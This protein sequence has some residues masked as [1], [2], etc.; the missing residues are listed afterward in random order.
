[1]IKDVMVRLDGT[2]A[3]DVRLAAAK[4]M[5]D[6]FDGQIIG[7]FFNVLPPPLVDEDPA[8]MLYAAE[9]ERAEEVGDTVE[10]VVAERLR[11]LQRPT[12]FRRFDVYQSDVPAAAAREAR[13]ADAFVALRPDG[14]PQEPENVVE[15]VL[16]GSGRQLYLVPERRP[17]GAAFNHIMIAWNGSREAARALA[18]AMP[19][20][21]RA[22]RVT[23]AIAIENDMPGD[24]GT[25]V[26]KHLKHHGIDAVLVHAT[27]NRDVAAALIA[28]ATRLKADVIVMG[29]YGHSRLREWLL[30]GVT[31]KLLHQGP[32]PLLMAH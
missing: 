18:E 23:V 16:F 6:L 1:M 14:N 24:I 2:A 32:F 31:Y 8:G 9:L 12:E 26:I 21:H 25:E 29:G 27:Q 22:R 15:S 11:E 20:L 7:L 19:F 3:D 4:D 5:A 10:A 17:V 28:E 30:G 13:T